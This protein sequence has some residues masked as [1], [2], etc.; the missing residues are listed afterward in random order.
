M[1]SKFQPNPPPLSYL[2]ISLPQIHFTFIEN[3]MTNDCDIK[4]VMFSSTFFPSLLFNAYLQGYTFQQVQEDLALNLYHFTY[5]T[6]SCGTVVRAHTFTC[7]SVQQWPMLHNQLCPPNGPIPCIHLWASA[8]M[9]YYTQRTFWTN[10][11]V[12]PIQLWVNTVISTINMLLWF[13]VV[14]LASN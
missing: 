6:Y 12:K 13:R 10:S 2:N 1:G 8:T 9:S 11:S 7:G 3:P 14:S 4:W 5:L